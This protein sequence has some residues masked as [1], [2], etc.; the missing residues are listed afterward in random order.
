MADCRADS[1][2]QTRWAAAFG[3]CTRDVEFEVLPTRWIVEDVRTDQPQPP[4]GA[5][6]RT[7]C[8]HRRCVRPP[9]H[10][11]HHAQAACRKPL[12]MNLNFSDRL[13][14]GRSLS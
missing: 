5:R 8:H 9:R 10:D 6:L 13:L 3:E 7:L 4:F 2:G 14:R 1:A 12:V 11:P